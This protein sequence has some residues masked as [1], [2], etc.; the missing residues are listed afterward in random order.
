[1]KECDQICIH[2]AI[3]SE[4]IK[5]KCIPYFC[6]FQYDIKSMKCIMNDHTGFSDINH[7]DMS[8]YR[9]MKESNHYTF[10]F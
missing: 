9:V 3:Q 5:D 7:K 6:V 8:L 10:Q 2:Y 1:M 4:Q